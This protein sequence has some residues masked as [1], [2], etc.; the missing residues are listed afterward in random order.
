MTSRF[1]NRYEFSVYNKE[2]LQYC[3]RF[4]LRPS[5]SDIME[6]ISSEQKTSNNKITWKNLNISDITCPDAGNYEFQI[7]DQPETY[8]IKLEY[9]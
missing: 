5:L 3:G 7:N 1:N 6:R 8:T 9:F 4:I 2:K